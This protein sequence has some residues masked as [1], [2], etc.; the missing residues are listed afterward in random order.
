MSIAALVFAILG[1]LGA[2]VL[3]WATFGT[4][5]IFALVGLILAIV[6]KKK[7]PNDK[8]AKIAFVIA[9]IGTILGVVIGVACGAVA[10]G[11]ALA[12]ASESYAAF[13]AL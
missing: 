5:S 8:M 13:L 7:D 9:I 6:A 3:G 2:V 4:S 12:A 11:G 10:C 1:L